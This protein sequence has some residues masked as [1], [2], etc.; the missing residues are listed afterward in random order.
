MC[1]RNTQNNTIKG[2]ELCRLCLSLKEKEEETQALQTSHEEMTANV[3]EE[4]K[5]GLEKL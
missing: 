3:M 5:A 2:N 1:V 4:H